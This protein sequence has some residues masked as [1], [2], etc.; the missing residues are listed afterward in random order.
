[1]DLLDPVAD[2]ICFGSVEL[3]IEEGA[4]LPPGMIAK[5]RFSPL[6]YLDMSTPDGRKFYSQGF[7]H[8]DLPVTL[9]YKNK[10]T[11]APGHAEAFVVGT[12]EEVELHGNE[13][14]GW[15]YLIDDADARRALVAIKTRAVKGVSADLGLGAAPMDPSQD[16]LA[17]EP[18]LRVVYPKSTLQGLT[19]VPIPAFPGT[20]I[21]IDDFVASAKVSRSS[22][23]KREWLSNPKLK[24]LTGIIVKDNGHFYGHLA[25][26]NQCHIG[27]PND[28]ETIPLDD[29]FDHFYTG[30]GVLCDNGEFV[31]TGR[32]FLGGQ[33]A[34]GGGS[35][36]EVI[37][38][39]ARTSLAWG[40]AVVGYDE[41]GIWV[42]GVVR[43]GLSE[44]VKYAARAS[45]LSGHWR[46][47]PEG[48]KL[49]CGLS[50]NVP[51]LPILST[52][53]SFVASAMPSALSVELEDVTHHAAWAQELSPQLPE[54]ITLTGSS[55]RNHAAF[56]DALHRADLKVL[57]SADGSGT[58]L[59]PDGPP[60]TDAGRPRV[61][62]WGSSP[63]TW[64]SSPSSRRSR[65]PRWICRSQPG[66]R[67]CSRSPVRR[68]R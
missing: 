67:I 18:Q 45:A 28:C 35:D 33:H 24:E 40:D 4:H 44:G 59:A 58:A 14:H 60:V 41:F 68:W 47:L 15:G 49:L 50:V 8:R 51:G 19:I 3:S 20:R 25:P 57:V 10:T 62:V 2:D 54:R 61:A 6:M 26:I 65:P 21:L 16:E 56:L 5:V 36:Q 46:R 64:T 31:R 17:A 63:R 52:G 1:M 9:F 55:A 37:D 38:Y 48:K 13:V 30:G 23:P 39:Y 34:P 53:D 32:M 7:E 43:P 29:N 66:A 12:V 11:D 27:N 22:K 42:S